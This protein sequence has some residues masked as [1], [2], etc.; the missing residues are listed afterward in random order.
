MLVYVSKTDAER[1]A[2]GLAEQLKHARWTIDE[3]ET[4]HAT[5][6]LEPERDSRERAES[7]VHFHPIALARR[8][9]FHPRRRS[10]A[11][12]YASCG[13]SSACRQSRSAAR[14]LNSGQREL[15]N[16]LLIRSLL[17]LQAALP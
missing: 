5:R 17:R 2:K 10:A 3:A 7:V 12:R 9:S 4:S 6:A 13:S 14:R 16:A 1:E 8:M 15:D 11:P